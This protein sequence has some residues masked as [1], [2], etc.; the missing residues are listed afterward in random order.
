MLGG[1]MRQH[2]FAPYAQYFLK[3]LQA[4]AAEGVPVQAVTCAKR[5]R[6]RSGRPHARLLVAAG[7]RNWI[8]Q[9]P[10]RSTASKE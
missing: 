8:R 7:I 9:E 3:F 5:S 2:Y 1:S 10:S 4:Y 6:H